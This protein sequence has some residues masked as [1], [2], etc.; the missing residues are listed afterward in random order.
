MNRV[1]SGGRIFI[2]HRSVLGWFRVVRKSTGFYQKLSD[3]AR[4]DQIL[5]RS[6]RISKRLGRSQRYLV[7]SWWDLGISGREQAESRR[8]LTRIKPN[9]NKLD[10]KLETCWSDT[11]E[12][13]EN[14]F[15]SLK[16]ANWPAV[17]GF[18]RLRPTVD[19]SPASGWLVLGPNR[20]VFASGLG[21]DFS[22][23]ALPLSLLQFLVFNFSSNFPIELVFIGSNTQDLFNWTLFYLFI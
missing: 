19:R 12:P 23:T 21:L 16:P 22:W 18:R 1:S 7:R 3:L 20:T 5:M 2:G 10:R 4:F 11:V 9:L 17:F 15:L 14:W 6:R 8:V 13:V